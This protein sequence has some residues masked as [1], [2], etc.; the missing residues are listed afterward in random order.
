MM[1]IVTVIWIHSISREASNGHRFQRWMRTVI[2]AT[3][4]AFC[5]VHLHSLHLHCNFNYNINE[6][7]VLTK[8]PADLL[9]R[10]NDLTGWHFLCVCDGMIQNADGTNNLQNRIIITAMGLGPS[11][12]VSQQVRKS[13]W[14]V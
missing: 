7:S 4:T 6:K 11:E 8:L 9:L 12:G 2:W 13:L 1:A 10:N 14:S 5:F 3:T